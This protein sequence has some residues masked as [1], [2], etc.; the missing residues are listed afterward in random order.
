MYLNIYSNV[1]ASSSYDAANDDDDDEKCKMRKEIWNIFFWERER[2][3]YAICN[4]C[5]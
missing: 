1:S 2:G 4:F 5:E 3:N